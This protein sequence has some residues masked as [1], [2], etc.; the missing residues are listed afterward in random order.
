MFGSEPPRT[1]ELFFPGRMAYV[2]ELEEDDD[3]GDEDEIGAH[4]AASD[5]PTTTIR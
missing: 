1:N 4:A 2:I 3:K 5:V